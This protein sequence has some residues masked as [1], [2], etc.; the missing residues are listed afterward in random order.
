MAHESR[1]MCSLL[2]PEMRYRKIYNVSNIKLTEETH[3]EQTRSET[4]AVAMREIQRTAA[5]P[6]RERKQ[7]SF[8]LQ[9][10]EAQRST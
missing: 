3:K 5:A 10:Q 9:R 1:E 8:S 6:E 4:S 7:R 2:I